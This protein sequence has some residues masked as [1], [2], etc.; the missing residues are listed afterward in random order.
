M[1]HRH[2]LDLPATA[3]LLGVPTQAVAR[4]VRK[5]VLPAVTRNGKTWF[6]RI[7]VETWARKMGMRVREPAKRPQLEGEEGSPVNP[8]LA[9]IHRGGLVPDLPGGSVEETFANLVRSIPLPASLPPEE[10]EQHLLERESLGTTGVGDGVAMPHPR[11]PLS[12]HIDEP[13]IYVARLR[14]PVGFKA[15]DGQPVTLLLL[16]LSTSL[17]NHLAL[18]SR[19]VHLLRTPKLRQDLEEADD[20]DQLLLLLEADLE[21]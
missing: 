7:K 20:L 19:V 5:G 17:K 12:S 15:I 8:V 11:Q 9:A 21:S 10:L 18:L 14:E 16:I 6:D 4:W 13:R 2:E 1:D 3:A